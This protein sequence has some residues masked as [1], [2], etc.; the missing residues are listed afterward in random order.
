M[1]IRPS[2]VALNRL[3]REEGSATGNRTELIESV[4]RYRSIWLDRTATKR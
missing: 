4:L 2:L 3:N 1:R